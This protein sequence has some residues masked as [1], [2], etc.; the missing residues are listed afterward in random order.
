[1]K[2]KIAFKTMLTVMTV[3]ILPFSNLGLLAGQ[4]QTSSKPN[5]S[6]LSEAFKTP[7]A[8]AVDV[9]PGNNTTALT[10]T[11]GKAQSSINQPS[12]TPLPT[13]NVVDATAPTSFGYQASIAGKQGVTAGQIQVLDNGNPVFNASSVSDANVQAAL[14]YI[15]NN[16]NPSDDF[17]LYIGGNV[18][19]SAATTANTGAAGT[20]SGLAG[21]AKSL[22]I[23]SAAAD[24]LSS[25]AGAAASGAA[26]ITLPSNVY[27]GTPTVFRNV[28][29][30][31]SNDN[32]F[33][34]GNAFATTVGS[35]M[36]GGPNIYGGSDSG[37]V[38]GDTN[39][40]I[41]ATGTGN[42]AIIGGSSSGGN[43]SG[44]THVT[45]TQT[46]TTILS[47]SGGNAAGGTIG[48]DTNLD[49]S[50]NIAAQVTNI[51]GGGIGTSS[52]PVTVGGNVTTVV[53][54][55][56][57]SARYQL[58]QGGVIN[59]NI[60][61]SIY[62]SLS[63]SG[64]WTGNSSNING[65]QTVFSNYN[66]GSFQGNIG[67]SGK[68][69]VI[70]NSYD[71]SAFSTGQALFTGGNA[72]TAASY[73]VAQ[74]TSTAATGITN[75]NI[76]NYVKS[77]FTTG[78]A[79]AV[80]GVVGGNGH[81]SMK[82]SPSQQGLGSSTDTNYGPNAATA[83]SWAQTP[84]ST[85]VAAARQITS[86]AIYGNVYTWLQSGA[87]ST[88]SGGGYNDWDG[89]AY[90]G[91]SNGYLEGTSVLEAGTANADNSV[92]GSGVVYGTAMSSGP[93]ATLAAQGTLAYGKSDT[94]TANSSGWDLWG[95]G[96]TVWT[97]RSAFLQ[98]GDSYLI[99]NN[100]VARWTYGGQSNGNQVGNSYNILNGGIVDTLE[101]GGYT[102]TTKW[103]STAAQV[104]MGQVN[105]FLSGGSWGDLYNT[106][107]ATVNVYNGYINAI[108]GGNYGQ[109]GT[110]TIAGNSTVNVYGGDFSGSPR[111]GT[112]QLAGG[113]FYNGLSAILGDTTLNLDLTG[114]TGNTFQFPS[115]N[116][117]LSGSTGYQNGYG[118]VG[119]SSDNSVNLIIKANAATATKL[120]SA[121][122]Y[123]DGSNGA[124]VNSGTVNI[125]IDAPGATVG[126][127][128]AS[129]RSNISSNAI[130]KD[131]NTTI[132]E[133][134]TIAGNVYNSSSGDNYTS[135]IA[136]NANS[137]TSTLTLGDGSAPATNNSIN[138]TGKVANFTSAKLNPGVT[139]MIA[140]GLLN[141]ASA[142]AAN[143][144]AT[145]SQSGSL[146]LGDN[147]TLGVSTT[148]SVISGSKLTVGKNV[149]ITSPY[150]NTVGLM[151]FSDLDM[152]AN[153]AGLTWIPT[154]TA[155][156]PTSSFVG[157]YWGT[158]KGFPVLTFNG[159]NAATKSGAANIT[160]GNFQGVDAA[161]NYAF[162]GD[163]TYASQSSPSNPSWI[164]Y[165]V[166]GQIRVFNTAD[167]NGATLGNWT[168]NLSGVTTGTP[169]AGN[170]MQAWA[171]TAAGTASNSIR[172]MYVM[173]YTSNVNPAFQFQAANGSYVQSRAVSAYNGTV[174]N[175]YSSYNPSFSVNH[176]GS[177]TGGATAGFTTNDYFTGNQQDGS[178]D[179][180]VF[181]SYIIESA[182]TSNQSKLNVGN[183]IIVN[184]SKAKSLTAPQIEGLMA[185][186][187]TGI[188]TNLQL[189]S[190]A[191]S[192]INGGIAGNNFGSYNSLPVSFRMNSA[193][194][195]G[196]LVIVTDHAKISAD[197]QNAL[198][199]Y[200]ATLTGDQAH[201]IQGDVNT[202]TP[203]ETAQP[204]VY[205]NGLNFYTG[206]NNQGVPPLAIDAS[207][208]VS[209]PTLSNANTLIPALQTISV[210][211][212]L[213]ANYSFGSLS[214]PAVL[215]I[216]VGFLEFT[217][218]PANINWGQLQIQNKSLTVFPSY[219][220][221]ASGATG[222]GQ[223][224]VTDTRTG[225]NATPW[226]LSVAVTQ[227][228]T[229]N[230]GKGNNSLAS[231][232]MYNDGT[233]TVN[234][235]DAASI[236]HT[237]TSKTPGVY[238]LNQNWGSASGQ[239][240]FLDVP[241]NA[242]HVGSYQGQLTWTL[243][244]APGNN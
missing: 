239:G 195:N 79:G 209:T 111:I 57:G 30:A 24:S 60:A 132:G 176:D 142:T 238:N 207:G 204:P 152:S 22:T 183:N 198:D 40:Y 107:N 82:I 102:A 91:S 13:N 119:A 175:S 122:I 106:G 217:S 10:P 139:A 185:I 171:D 158:Q 149:Q 69:N 237:E 170:T 140:G 14:N 113:P 240:L 173:Q 227:A 66:G 172:V 130:Y 225:S 154:G 157:A 226:Q 112:K 11:A 81:D 68:G 19:L 224:V 84:A 108:A 165:V 48:K 117:Y 93:E 83:A 210:S 23:V 134:S 196:N 124:T 21:K 150:V 121:T 229:E 218:A 37:N 215:T 188:P 33:A 223:L 179:Q 3:S 187:G 136:N 16:A 186:T 17:V 174:L 2:K 45:V 42:W 148:S 89:F 128:Y 131:V 8:S 26:T 190:P 101:G 153:G 78:T 191:L 194:A 234:L 222:T 7:V 61:G 32:I 70:S 103:G 216:N 220:G 214:M 6:K 95:G 110:E 189:S 43:I 86:N 241:V 228:F 52:N 161:K 244:S 137:G 96:G 27:L 114:P 75:A 87:M 50:G 211:G 41:G 235:S 159:G 123:G 90:G 28:T 213:T 200:D 133:G 46:S 9:T 231:Y 85:V 72:G 109:A 64:G 67:T 39:V 143:H 141:G 76:V 193:T 205:A 97:Y 73:S 162:L 203:D 145:Y 115:G 25:P 160:P 212:T 98:N 38:S 243:E 65:S 116:T 94:S 31:A 120:A 177:V 242:Q 202:N 127:V 118:T 156:A 147:S 49:L 99:H 104:N 80:Y 167:A 180:N 47:A 105:W 74:S 232:L 184:E 164:A 221:D 15:S 56:S 129:Y 1:M 18:T 182:I 197:G 192:A 233:Q 92:G 71:T 36:T 230:D 208:K 77:A 199:V 5:L 138:I 236:V 35:W 163:Y 88:T 144:A 166:P 44:S 125:T 12:R 178:N 169:V 151:N 181:G 168:H 51:Y 59:G 29:F 146:T 126:N 201:A 34:Q 4:G 62:N 100:D 54:S 219:S 155:S 53:K 20:F 206:I 135:A 63:G 58:Y 55:T